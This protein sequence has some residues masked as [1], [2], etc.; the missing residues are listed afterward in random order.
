MSVCK[1]LKSYSR[2]HEKLADLFSLLAVAL[3]FGTILLAVFYYGMIGNWIAKDMVLHLPIVVAAIVLDI[4][5]IFAFLNIGSSRFSEDGE[6]ESCF[7]TFK[8]RRTGAGSPLTALG[9]W[10]KHM[11]HV[12]RKH[13]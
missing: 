11:E 2:T 8:G 12:N 6:E 3:F 9:N 1:Q 10:V 5:L 7:G 4:F 13:R